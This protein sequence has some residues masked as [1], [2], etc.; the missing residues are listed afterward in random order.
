MMTKSISFLVQMRE[1]VAAERVQLLILI[2]MSVA[3]VALTAAATF[4]DQTLFER[5]LGR[6]NP[7]LASVGIAVVGGVLLLT[8]LS[9]GWFSVY[10][11]AGVA[12]WLWVIVPAV[13]LAA[14]MIVVDTRVAFPE[15]MNALLPHS[16]MY[17]PVIGYAVEIL[18]H[19]LPLSI[20]LFLLSVFL[21]N[22]RFEAIVWP[23]ILVVS[24]LEPVFQARFSVGREPAWT[25]A[26][27]AAHLLVFNLIQLALFK[28]Y[29][30]VTMYGFRLVYYALWHIVWGQLRLGLLF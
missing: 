26:Y 6:I 8:L 3:F 14:A 25:V 4:A 7:I 18:F 24:L 1:T 2:G 17:Y 15:D 12:R 10:T 19:V 16:L 29:D 5:W 11:R 20:L 28:R 22:T 21:G 9:R 30:F 13:L 27:V 23:A